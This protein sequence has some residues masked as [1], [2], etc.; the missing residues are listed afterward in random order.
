VALKGVWKET[1]DMFGTDLIVFNQIDTA[2]EINRYQVK[3]GDSALS[4]GDIETIFDHMY[5]CFTDTE[6]TALKTQLELADV[7]VKLVLLTTR[8]VSKAGLEVV[9]KLR[10][11]F[12]HASVELITRAT[13][14]ADKLWGPAITRW[15]SKFGVKAYL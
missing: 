3:L 12:A 13:A 2:L 14:V 7:R 8:P 9:E 11:K 5:R 6:A 10:A 15:A 1:P 4:P